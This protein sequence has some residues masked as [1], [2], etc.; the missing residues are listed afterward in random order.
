[1]DFKYKITKFDSENKL[2]VVV[3]EDESWAE[4]RLVEPLPATLEELDK[5]VSLHTAPVEVMEA[6]QNVTADLSFIQNA[7]DTER[8]TERF[9]INPIATA[10]PV[11][12]PSLEVTL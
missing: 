6:R 7:V 10:M 8:T 3:Y 12:V 2:V 9:R 11:Q 5:I 1:M 4:I